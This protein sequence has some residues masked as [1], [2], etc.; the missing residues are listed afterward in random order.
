MEAMAEQEECM[1]QEEMVVSEATFRK[2]TFLI[3]S[4]SQ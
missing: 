2:I 3:L 4:L 1:H